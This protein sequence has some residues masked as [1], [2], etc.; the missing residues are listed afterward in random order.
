MADTV[1]SGDMSSELTHFRGLWETRG[2]SPVNHSP[3]IWDERAQEWIDDLEADG[4]DSHSTIARASATAEYLRWRGLLKAA[5]TVVDVGCGPGAFVAEF[6]KSVY[7]ATGIDYSARFIDFAAGY[8][9]ERGV[10]NT[11][12]A[13]HDFFALD[14]AAAGYERAFDLVFTSITPASSGKG[15]L[16]KLMRMSRAHCNNVSFVHA[17][18]SLAERVTR[19]VFGHDFRPRWD[20]AGFYTMTNLLWLEGFY[21]ETYYYDDVRDET[22]QPSLRSASECAQL[23]RHYDEE[24]VKKVLNYMEKLGTIERHTE[25]RY[26]SILWNVNRQDKRK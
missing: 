22:V 20:G 3:E 25:F 17:G 6:A 11:T 12:F 26:G 9:T 14:I 13:R 8:A 21:P 1:H 16:E 15:C 23:C 2:N 10:S 18:D 4:D 5:D 7:H 19:D 24:D